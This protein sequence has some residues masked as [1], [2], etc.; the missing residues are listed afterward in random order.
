MISDDSRVTSNEWRISQADWVGFRTETDHKLSQVHFTGDFHADVITFANC[1]TSAADMYIGKSVISASRRNSPWW[2]ENCSAA[3][4]ECK[5]ALNKYR[6]IRSEENLIIFKKMRAKAKLVLKQSKKASWRN[7]TSSITSDTPPT[8]IWAKIK[9]MSGNKTHS[10]IPALT[11]RNDLITDDQQRANLLGESFQ[12]KTNN[13]YNPNPSPLDAEDTP[14]PSIAQQSDSNSL[15]LP[16]T[17]Q[18]LLTTLPTCKHS[19]AGPDDIPFI[20]LKNLSTYSLTKLLDLYNFV[21][22][23]K[24]FPNLWRDSIV[25]PIR[26]NDKPPTDPSSYRSIS[27]TCTMCKLL[28]KI[29]NKRLLWYLQKHK[30]LDPAQSGLDQIAVRQITYYCYNRTS[31]KLS[32]INRT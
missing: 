17:F 31:S 5:K 24:E 6:R 14:I 23:N 9:Q 27:L 16:L 30:I 29:L 19:A 21:W 3:V 1:I 15:N 28:E 2:N 10:K 18:E 8:Q 32:K 12:A 13:H 22:M 11:Y 26:K 4:R 20:F 7:Y 25:L